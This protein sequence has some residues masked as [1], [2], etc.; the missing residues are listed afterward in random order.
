MRRLY[1]LSALCLL[2]CGTSLAQVAQQNFIHKKVAGY[3]SYKT[4]MNVAPLQRDG[5]VIWSCDFEEGCPEY[6]IAKEDGTDT[7][8]QVITEADYP[9]E[10][11]VPSTGRCYFL[12]MNYTGHPGNS[13]PHQQLSETPAHWA[14]LDAGSDLY[15]AAPTIDASL[16]FTGINLSSTSMPKLQFIQS[17]RALNT[18]S[19]DIYVSRCNRGLCRSYNRCNRKKRNKI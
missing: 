11:Y 19:E 10:M 1:F 5:N 13:D 16:T 18:A 8:W 7:D 2:I 12:P 6:I 17:W 14:F 4:I 3:N 15:P 9:D